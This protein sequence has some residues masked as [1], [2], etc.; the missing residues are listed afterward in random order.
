AAGEPWFEAPDGKKNIMEHM[1]NRDEVMPRSVFA[2]PDW[3]ADN[4]DE[5]NERFKAWMAK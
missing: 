3:W 1:P 2:N 5:V 4:G